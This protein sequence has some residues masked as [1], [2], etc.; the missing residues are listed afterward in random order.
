M[1][2]FPSNLPLFSQTHP[3]VEEGHEAVTLGLPCGHVLHHTSISVDNS[4]VQEQ[5]TRY[6]LWFPWC[7][8]GD[9]DTYD[10][11]PNGPKAALTSS[12]VISGLRSPTKT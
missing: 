9:P 8:P 12:V 5:K 10:I 1:R 2:I 11:L 7:W 4:T 3:F 6:Q